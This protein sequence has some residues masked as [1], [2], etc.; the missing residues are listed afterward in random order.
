MTSQHHGNEIVKISASFFAPMF[1]S[2]EQQMDQ[3]FIKRDAFLDQVIASEL[4][5]RSQGLRR[6][7][8]LCKGQS[9]YLRMPEK[10]RGRRCRS[11]EASQFEGT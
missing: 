3:A 4:P 7:E 8:A 1:A 11:T 5:A 9:V 6:Q 2:F 10:T